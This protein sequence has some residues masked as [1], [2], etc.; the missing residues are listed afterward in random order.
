MA[1]ENLPKA[2]HLPGDPSE[3]LYDQAVVE[4]HQD[5]VLPTGNQLQDEGSATNSMNFI[6]FLKLHPENSIMLPLSDGN[7]GI[8]AQ[9]SSQ[10]TDKGAILATENR[11]GA[12]ERTKEVGVGGQTQGQVSG[13]YF[14]SQ[15]DPRWA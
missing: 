9:K 2:A 15:T 8:A 7:Y 11:V 5:E 1:W 4:V 10:T 12:E 14:G 6:C 13:S 3:G